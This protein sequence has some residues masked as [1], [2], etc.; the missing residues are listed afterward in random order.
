[1]RAWG[2]APIR[3]RQEGLEVKAE[4]F[5]QFF[6]NKNIAFYAYFDQNSYFK[7]ITF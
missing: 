6:K 2:E 4:R 5:L 1:M 3:R 7:A